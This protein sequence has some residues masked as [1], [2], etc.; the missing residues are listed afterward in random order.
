MHGNVACLTDACCLCVVT[1]PPLEGMMG[2]YRS[3]MGPLL[4]HEGMVSMTGIPPHHMGG[5]VPP[6]HLLPV[7]PGFLG[8][9]HF[10][11]ST[12][13]AAPSAPQSL[14]SYESDLLEG[15]PEPYPNSVSYEPEH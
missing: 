14:P 8:M 7:M 3:A 2:V 12:V 5:P 10:G 4:G 11:K 6:P 13:M 9:P 1:L 15:I